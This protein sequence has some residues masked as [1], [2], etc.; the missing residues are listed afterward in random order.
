VRPD[1]SAATVS[2]AG[3]AAIG[4]VVERLR[5]EANHLIFG[6][7]HRRGPMPREDDWVAG[8]GTRLLNAGSWVYAPSLVG[9]TARESPYWPGTVALLEDDRPPRLVHALDSLSREELAARD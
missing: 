4:E 2:R 5:I 3:I 8:A 1:L 7:T 6:H 9:E